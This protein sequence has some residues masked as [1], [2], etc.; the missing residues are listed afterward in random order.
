MT[1]VKPKYRIPDE[2]N[3]ERG[4]CFAAALGS[5]PVLR[6]DAGDEFGI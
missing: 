4:G 5:F 3:E 6:Q 1:T 2:S